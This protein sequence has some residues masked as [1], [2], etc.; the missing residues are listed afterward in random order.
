MKA[1]YQVCSTENLLMI[2]FLSLVHNHSRCPRA[3]FVREHQ[4]LY[5]MLENFLN[6]KK[7]IVRIS[8]INSHLT[9]VENK[10]HVFLPIRLN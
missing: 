4:Q 3:V 9:C 1:I 7:S 6:D 10:S 5:Y 8:I 2:E